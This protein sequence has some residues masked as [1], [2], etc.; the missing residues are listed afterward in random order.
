MRRVC[1][2]CEEEIAIVQFKNGAIC[3]ICLM[4]VK[5]SA[6]DY[7]TNNKKISRQNIR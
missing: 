6:T 5:E 4:H 3:P 2:V 7:E 1:S